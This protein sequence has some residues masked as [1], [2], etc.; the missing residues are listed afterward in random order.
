MRQHGTGFS[1]AS[2]RRRSG[3]MSL[4][5][6]RQRG[7]VA[8]IVAL[9]MVVLVGFVGLALDLGKLF[10]TKTEL[11]N[12]VDSCALAAARELTGANNNQLT[13][14]EAA[15][16]TSGTS[17]NV[18]FQDEQIVINTDSDVTFSDQL[19]GTY[20]TKGA[21]ANPLN[22]KFS[23]CTAER[24]GIANWFIQVLGIGDQQ[25]NATAVASL[26]P[27]QTTC[28]IPV[29]VCKADID[30]SIP[31]DWIE[32]A[33]GPGGDL[34]GGFKWVDF[35]PPAGGASELSAHL[36]GSGECTLPAIGS[37]VGEGGVISS[38]SKG[39][40]SRYGIYRNPV[41]SGP[42]QTGFAV[43]DS[44]G[45][46][47]TEVNWP[48]QFDAFSDFT[49]QRAVNAAYQGDAS[50]GLN[51]EGGGSTT[52]NSAFLLANGAD[53]RLGTVAVIDCPTLDAGAPTAPVESWACVLMLHPINFNQGGSGTGATRMFLEYLGNSDDPSSPCASSG[54]VG[55]AT[56]AGPLV[57]S[58]VQ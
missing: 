48:S 8:I 27:G 54:A 56:S 58:L 40:N 25:V 17:N 7:V 12:S 35:T 29:G 11:Q 26:L 20:Q 3:L 39:W 49:S 13:L 19:N 4:H 23:R 16:I 44:T 45:Y 14:A 46:A 22:M 53:R 18:L 10:V 2:R 31:G 43:P 28:A 41:V 55:S 38:L 21:V 15:G 32:G 1:S 6:K 9:S 52:Q 42:G 37:I 50:T 5:D 47:Y 24:A 33:I 30:A 34:T 57:P 51:A 36:T